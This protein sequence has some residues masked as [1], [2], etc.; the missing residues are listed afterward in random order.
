VV[1]EDVVVGDVG[2][3]VGVDQVLVGYDVGALLLGN[4]DVALSSEI[5]DIVVGFDLD[6]LVILSIVEQIARDLVVA[7]DP[8][9]EPAEY[10]SWAPR[11][12]W[13]KSWC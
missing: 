8:D 1:D 10:A 12:S 11:G 7:V 4:R 5:A 9:I 13:N 3:I 2:E 6:A